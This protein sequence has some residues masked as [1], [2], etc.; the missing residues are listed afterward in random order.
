M[1]KKKKG[2]KKLKVDGFTGAA[3]T[4]GSVGRK[5]KNV[6]AFKQAVAFSSSEKTVVSHV[7]KTKGARTALQL[8]GAIK[9]KRKSAGSFNDDL[10]KAFGKKLKV[11]KGKTKSGTALLTLSNKKK[12]KKK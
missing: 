9:Q 2:K 6:S 1:A 12:K 10:S 8:A 11:K 3:T 5:L 4:S 7:K